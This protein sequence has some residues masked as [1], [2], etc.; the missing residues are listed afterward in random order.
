MKTRSER[1]K[2]VIYLIKLRD[3]LKMAHDLDD[4]ELVNYI[5]SIMIE[6]LMHAYKIDEE[7]AIMKFN[8]I[9]KG[10]DY[11]KPV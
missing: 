7:Y 3:Q 1:F 5:R 2:A 10:I 8:G 6:S 4:A 11:I 9:V